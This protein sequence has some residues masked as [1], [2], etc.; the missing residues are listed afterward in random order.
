MYVLEQLWTG[1]LLKLI[2]LY[3]YLQV[4]YNLFS[5]TLEFGIIIQKFWNLSNQ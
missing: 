4:L 5:H 1:I 2:I 3:K